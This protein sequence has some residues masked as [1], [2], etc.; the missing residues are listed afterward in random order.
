MQCMVGS[1]NDTTAI[2][3]SASCSETYKSVLVDHLNSDHS[4]TIAN[5]NGD[6]IMRGSPYK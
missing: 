3:K 2:D 4:R 1:R 6:F 5:R